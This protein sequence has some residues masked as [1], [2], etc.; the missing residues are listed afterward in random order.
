MMAV[1]LSGCGQTSQAEGIVARW[2]LQPDVPVQGDPAIATLTLRDANGA[3]VP[4]ARLELEAHMP[5]PGM[6]PVVSTPREVGDGVY[7]AP[8]QFTMPGR[9]TLVA[10]GVLRDGRRLLESHDIT[11]VK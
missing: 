6:A 4:G 5:H 1:P 11:A 9:W 10:S 2:T 3:P 7:V 8:L